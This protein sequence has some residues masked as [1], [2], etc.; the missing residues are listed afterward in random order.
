MMPKSKD[1]NGNEL[2]GS[3][4]LVIWLHEHELTRG[5]SKT[6]ANHHENGFC[7]YWNYVIIVEIFLFQS[8]TSEAFFQLQSAISAFGSR[9][10][11]VK[12]KLWPICKAHKVY[13]N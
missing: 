6:P 10:Y 8:R 1:I 13:S 5:Q 9:E 3:G 2:F 4:H 11:G 7:L 12:V